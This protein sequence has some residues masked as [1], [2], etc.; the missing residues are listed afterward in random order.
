MA[1]T[2][3]SPFRTLNDDVL[4][5]LLSGVPLDDHDATAAACRA[6]R[7]VIRGPLFPELRRRYGLAET[8]AGTGDIMH[9]FAHDGR[10]VVVNESGLAFHRGTGSDDWSPLD[11]DIAPPQQLYDDPPDSVMSN[12]FASVV[13][14]SVL[15]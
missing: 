6:F 15:L 5:R 11:L 13:G 9:A 10:I 7:A 1:T 3:N 4:R 14:G 12:G 8:I 2:N